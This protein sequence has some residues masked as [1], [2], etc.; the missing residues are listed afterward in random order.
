MKIWNDEINLYEMSD[1]LA[2][3][4]FVYLSV[5]SIAINFVTNRLGIREFNGAIKAVIVVG[6][7]AFG[8]Q[9]IVRKVRA[10]DGIFVLAIAAA[11]IIM[12]MVYPDV[13]YMI[14]L[15]STDFFLTILPYYFVGVLFGSG[16]IRTDRLLIIA[17]LVIIFTALVIASN[18]T[19]E[20]LMGYAYRLVPYLMLVTYS[21]LGMKKWI[22]LIFMIGGIVLLAVTVTRGAILMYLIFFV[23]ICLIK[24]TRKTIVAALIAAFVFSIEAARDTVISALERFFTNNNLNMRLFKFLSRGNIAADN[25]RQEIL[26]EVGKMISAHPVRGNGLYAD[27]VASLNV[28]RVLSKNPNGLYAHNLFY[29]IFCQWGVILGTAILAFLAWIIIRAAR[30]G[31]YKQRIAL[32]I[33]SLSTLGKLMFSGSYLQEEGFFILIGFAVA[34]VRTRKEEMAG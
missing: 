22:D 13:R 24:H 33:L 15:R 28:D 26:D 5:I 14:E 30:L 31:S 8:I 2:E 11:F 17:R 12:W 6:V 20:E 9:T 4:F 1:S 29:E 7:A 3:F 32:L 18:G 25:G 16:A 27:R 19:A 23:V 21:F 10:F 34:V